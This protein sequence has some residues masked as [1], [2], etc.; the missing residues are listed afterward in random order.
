MDSTSYNLKTKGES[1]LP[2]RL[3]QMCS[4]FKH[5]GWNTASIQKYIV[6][7][8]YISLETKT[9]QNLQTKQPEADNCR[10]VFDYGIWRLLNFLMEK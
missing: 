2:E 10:L 8:F 1:L 7:K 6:W 3:S 9:L 4:D 5:M